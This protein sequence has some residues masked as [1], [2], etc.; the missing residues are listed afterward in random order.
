MA[1][2]VDA[3][4]VTPTAPPPPLKA[5]RSVIDRVPLCDT[6]DPA[7]LEAWYGPFGYADHFRKVVLSSCK[8]VERARAQ[9]S[10][11][12]AKLDSLAHINDRYVDFLIDSLNGR[13]M[14]EKNVRES[15]NRGYG[16]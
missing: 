15:M 13:R 10:I 2:K 8:E 16:A 9:S 4:G 14:R 5:G 6:N 12:E 3:I 7:D 1:D 11:S